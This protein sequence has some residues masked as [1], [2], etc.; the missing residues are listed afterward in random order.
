MQ[1]LRRLLAQLDP[2]PVP[3][4]VND[5]AWDEANNASKQTRR[6]QMGGTVSTSIISNTVN[7]AILGVDLTLAEV[8]EAVD[9]G[10]ERV[11]NFISGSELEWI[12]EGDV[13]AAEEKLTAIKATLGCFADAAN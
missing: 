4:L 13:R 9:T 12:K 11:A 5:E 2:W 8:L 1:R 10:F 7:D 3:A 6:M